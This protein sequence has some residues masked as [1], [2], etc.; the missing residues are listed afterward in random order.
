MF[1][2]L[3][4]WVQSYKIQKYQPNIFYNLEKFANFA[5]NYKT[6]I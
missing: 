3:V 2:W 1:I 4:F 6:N 5:P